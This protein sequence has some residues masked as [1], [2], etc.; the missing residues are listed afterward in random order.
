ME[1]ILRALTTSSGRSSITAIMCGDD[2]IR[3][4]ESVTEENENKETYICEKSHL[5]CANGKFPAS[6]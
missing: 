4:A 5:Q 1:D 2:I 6:K 3:L